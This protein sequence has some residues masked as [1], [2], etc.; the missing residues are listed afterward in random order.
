M[1]TPVTVI[2]GTDRIGDGC[3]RAVLSAAGRPGL[4][5]AAVAADHASLVATLH[6]NRDCRRLKGRAVVRSDDRLGFDLE[7]G[8]WQFRRWELGFGREL[9]VGWPVGRW[10]LDVGSLDFVS[11]YTEYCDQ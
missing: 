2:M 7:V 1:D 4:S 6:D 8:A 10:E 3:Y 5:S 9:G 11:N